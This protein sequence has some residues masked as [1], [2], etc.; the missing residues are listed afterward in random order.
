MM[1]IS[2][3]IFSVDMTAASNY[4]SNLIQRTKGGIPICCHSFV[5]SGKSSFCK[6]A[7]LGK[8]FKVLLGREELSMYESS[9]CM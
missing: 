3:A 8:G 4:G 5:M 1:S 2:M 9:V 7:D 6:A